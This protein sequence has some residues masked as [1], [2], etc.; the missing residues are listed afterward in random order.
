M[1]TSARLSS[2]ARARIAN[3]LR[4]VC[5]RISRRVRFESALDAPPHHVSVLAHLQRGA[6]SPGELADLEK[7]SAPSMTRTVQALVE[8]GLAE[9]GG[10]PTDGRQVVVAITPA[11]RELLAEAR[12]RRDAWLSV[13]MDQLSDDELDIVRRATEVIDRVILEGGDD[14]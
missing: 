12:R 9:R 7:V 1:S 6:R 8:R 2:A 3:D 4:L 13:R 14:R 5:M 11:G 10:H